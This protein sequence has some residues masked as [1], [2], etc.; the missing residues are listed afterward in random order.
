MI[1]VVQSNRIEALA[2]TLAGDVALPGTD[3]RIPDTIVVPNAGMARWLQM[4]IAR[5]HDIAAHLAFPLPAQFLWDAHR[6]VLGDVPERS[7]FDPEVLA[8][9]IAGTLPGLIS[10]PRFAEVAAYL[11][12]DDP[13]LLHEFCRRLAATFD[14]YL[15][16]RPD[17]IRD[18]DAGG[19]DHW[20]AVLW[21][22]LQ[23]GGGPHRVALQETFESRLVEDPGLARALPAR[24]ALFAVTA[25]PPAYLQAFASLGEHVDVTLYLVNPCREWWGDIVPDRDAARRA[26]AA[27][28][29]RDDLHYE[30]GQPLLA[31]FGRQGRDVLRAVQDLDAPTDERFV[32]EGNSAPP[33]SM[34]HTLQRDILDLVD[35]ADAPAPPDFGA[36]GDGSIQVHGCHGPMR[37]VEVLHDRLR[38][39]LDHDGDLTPSDILVMAPDIE[40]YA[41]LIDSVF[42]T[43]HGGPRIPYAVADRTLRSES[44]LAE[45]L[46]RI[47]ELPGSRYEADR[48]VGLLDVEAVRRRFGL[49]PDDLDRIRGW[50]DKAAIRWEVDAVARAG[51]GLPAVREHT[52]RAGLDRLVLGYAIAGDGTR[53]VAD[54]LP[55]EGIEGSDARVLGRFHAFAEAAFGLRDERAVGRPPW[56][57]FATFGEVL[58]RFVVAAGDEEQAELLALRGALRRLADDALAAGADFDVPYEVAL[59]HLRARLD[60]PA[61]AARFLT[62]GVTFCAMVPMRSVPF[63]VV[64]MLGMNADAFPRRDAI[65]GFDRMQ[66]EPRSGDRSRRDEDRYLFLEA[67]LAARDRVLITHV[68]GDMRDDTRRPPAGPVSELIDW[69][70][71]RF[72]LDPGDD[73][74]DPAV[75]LR[76]ALQPFSRRGFE[77]EGSVGGDDWKRRFSYRADMVPP[78]T[79]DS[80]PAPFFTARL[81]AVEGELLDPGID[82]LVRFFKNP[83][84]AFLTRVGVKLPGRE[85]GIESSEPFALESLER[86]SL[87]QVLRALREG[88]HSQHAAA[89]VA[90]AAGRLPHAAVGE[91]AAARAVAEV[92]ALA[93]RLR[94]WIEADPRPDA[95]VDVFVEDVRIAG[96]LAGLTAIGA[97][98]FRLG[99]TRAID[100]FGA[101]LR[102]LLLCAVDPQGVPARSTWIA[103][104]QVFSLA[105]V[106]DPRAHLAD[107]V[108]A[109]RTGLRAP[110]PFLPETSWAWVVAGDG[111]SRSEAG[112]VYDGT[113]RRAG[114]GQD[115]SAR[116][117]FR[118]SYL[119]DVPE[120]ATWANRLLRPVVDHTTE[121]G[122]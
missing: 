71:A 58:D 47:L 54:V 102:H 2:A 15:V 37:E 1:R 89:V 84:E 85:G 25:L 98:S 82:G 112:K 20:Q 43:A 76:H 80:E 77:E 44:T 22:A 75:S 62:G 26:A 87:K 30:A 46:L 51:H 7:P 65:V 83:A 63:R 50:L 101:W 33:G 119:L 10:D 12:D 78:A 39:M 90:R 100:R 64:C 116:L 13:V 67:L 113:D 36:W 73:K 21:R 96:R 53:P 28:T 69:L 93:A 49:N 104:D 56:A 115:P 114:E 14:R 103:E 32:P 92:D 74:R 57:W 118:G 19:A 9:R 52:W 106:D 95:E 99:R 117:V 27:G 17:W 72:G 34:L 41:P 66:F 120:F 88:G 8:W 24:V 5:E 45:S 70:A 121:G 94:P 107:I 4:E 18:W 11:R 42:G 109:Y 23:D 91:V 61:G 105:P 122:P 35:P 16:Y 97:W 38:A 48:V 110:L 55:V 31:S 68:A 29:P 111:K 81:Q 3:P 40:T 108:D 59:L 86:W 79:A 6:A 60:T